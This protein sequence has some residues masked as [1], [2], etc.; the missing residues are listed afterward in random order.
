MWEPNPY[1]NPWTGSTPTTNVYS[2]NAKNQ[3]NGQTYDLAG[4]LLNVNGLTANYNAENQL[5]S[6][7]ATVGGGA[8]TLT[9]DAVGRRVQKTITGTSGSTSTVYFYDAFGQLAAENVN[10]AWSRDY[11]RDGK[12]NLIATENASGPCT[13]C[14]FSHDPP[15]QRAP[16]YRSKRLNRRPP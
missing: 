13:P 4:N 16:R 8:E 5:Y 3:V 14:Y 7:N 11:I 12:G 10:G 15:R 1:G 9:Y 2:Q 6:L